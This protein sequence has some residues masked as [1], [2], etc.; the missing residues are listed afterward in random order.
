M[1]LT[2]ELCV[3]VNIQAKVVNVETQACDTNINFELYIS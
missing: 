1:A 3:P 2:L